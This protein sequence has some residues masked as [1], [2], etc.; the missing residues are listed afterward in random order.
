MRPNGVLCIA[1]ATATGKSAL[2]IAVAERVGGEVISADAFAAY[3]GMDVGT[4][5]PTLEERARVP[6]HLVDVKDPDEAYSAGEF[7][8]RA[9]AIAEEILSRGKLP[10][11]CGGTGFYVRSFFGG[12]FE[13]PTRDERLRAAL[14]AVATR[15]GTAFLTRMVDV[16]EPAVSS[17]VLPGD[18]VRATRLLE[19]LLTTGRRVSDLFATRPG[20]SWERP[21]V[22]VLLVLPRPELYERIS[23]RFSRTFETSF[24]EEVRR[25]LEAG[26]AVSA[27]GFAAIGYRDT[28]ELVQG[29]IDQEEWR[30]RVLRATRR[31]AKRQETWFR[32]EPGL[33][34]VRADRPDLTDF[35]LAEARPL[36]S[37]SEGGER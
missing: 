30:E 20:P 37:G 24:P 8:R 12:L 14:A 1:G 35:T 5:K 4:A 28:A 29:R 33:V 15:R 10:I 7:A 34:P 16:L 18:A 2:A 25:L 6:H 9:R 11:V 17:R 21:A 32:K 23:A 31:F 3:R 27:P 36:F 13:G 26:W 22:K 19:I